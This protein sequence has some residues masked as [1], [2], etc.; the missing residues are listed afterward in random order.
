MT[1][2]FTYEEIAAIINKVVK[3]RIELSYVEKRKLTAK[4]GYITEMLSLG[5]IRRWKI[6]DFWGA[7]P[8]PWTK[9]EH[10][11]YTK[12]VSIEITQIH[13][14]L[15]LKITGD[16][17]DFIECYSFLKT[18]KSKTILNGNKDNSIELFID[19]TECLKNKFDKNFLTFDKINLSPNYVSISLNFS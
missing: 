19:I 1:L 8:S 13:Q 15:V 17:D 3:D 14:T 4:F 16:S 18:V 12:S 6:V 9:Y 2:R 10:S 7:M 11:H 5:E